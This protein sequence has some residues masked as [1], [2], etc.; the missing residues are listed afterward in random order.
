MGLPE[1]IEIGNEI[2]KNSEGKNHLTCLITETPEDNANG[3]YG[4][5]VGEDTGDRVVGIYNFNVYVP[6]MRIMFDDPLSG[7]ELTLF[8]WRTQMIK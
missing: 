8:Q 3:R 4:I 7:D 2:E 6:V 1:I 5:K